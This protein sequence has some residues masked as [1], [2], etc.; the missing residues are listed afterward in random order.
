MAD[1]ALQIVITAKDEAAKVLKGIGSEAE[2]MGSKLRSA[3]APLAA[4]AAGFLSFKTIESAV[5][6]TAELGGEIRKVA[7]ETGLAAE[8]ASR[9]V[10]VAKELGLGAD[11]LSR[12]FGIFSKNLINTRDA[13]QQGK[14]AANPFSNSLKS[15]EV[16]MQNTDG[17]F[18]DGLAVFKDLADRFKTLPDGPEKTARAIDIFGRS[19]K[20]MI[21]ILNK[22]SEGIAELAKEADKLGLTFSAENLEKT[23]Q[24]TLAQRE[25][26]EAVNGLK[27]A[28]GLEVMPVLTEFSH[29]FTEHQADV[30]SFIHDAFDV[31]SDFAKDFKEGLGTIKD[32]L[33]WIPD[34]KGEVIA[35]VALIGIAMAAAWGPESLAF[36][37]IAG[38]IAF[39]GQAKTVGGGLFSKLQG[40]RSLPEAAIDQ[41][42]AQ[43]PQTDPA[44]QPGG[45]LFG[46]PGT[47]LGPANDATVTAFR[48][49]LKDEEDARKRAGQALDDNGKAAEEA[50]KAAQAALRAQERYNE[51]V[52][53]FNDEVKAFNEQ[54]GAVVRSFLSF[55]A[56]K[57]AV[58]ALFGSPTREQAD[59]ALLTDEE[60]LRKLR[61]GDKSVHFGAGE[62]P[63]TGA[64]NEKQLS[65]L[66]QQHKVEQDR[67]TAANNLLITEQQQET[68]AGK[69][70]DL[71]A[72]QS[73]LIREKLNPSIT[74]LIP[75]LKTA[76]SE[77]ETLGTKI[78]TGTDVA[79]AALLGFARN[80]TDFKWPTYPTFK[81][82]NAPLIVKFS[83]PAWAP[84][85]DQSMLGVAP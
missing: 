25:F 68:E 49:Q 63:G 66:E 37:G 60:K 12:S 19:G 67:I 34:N 5:A 3:A 30:R 54:L 36:I 45:P 46:L 84:F 24:Y 56:I 70:R 16:N 21:P 74:D 31:G 53:K 72:A 62:G 52:G 58:S 64:K 59:L 29:W 23:R 79:N 27:V 44:R 6:T 85:G 11:D 75:Q 13:I 26:G 39:L 38:I 32:A 82:P 51:A 69:L 35:A 81:D 55:S 4:L 50:L 15:L 7:R 65:L 80:L 78:A 77:Y 22:G 61:F 8:D 42:H 33:A 73:T 48:Q 10:F 2:S 57:S 43:F 18:R 1:A 40:G 20:D 9:F 28:I 41:F 76:Q 14:D 83:G 17:T 47:P 71:M